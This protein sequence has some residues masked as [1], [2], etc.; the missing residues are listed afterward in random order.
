MQRICSP[1]D[2]RFLYFD[3]R[4]SKAIEQ[5]IYIL[6]KKKR[7]HNLAFY[8]EVIIYKVARIFSYM[9]ILKI[10]IICISFLNK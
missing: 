7:T 10:F 4:N 6:K 1:N 2:C 9:G 8:T 5:A 3:T